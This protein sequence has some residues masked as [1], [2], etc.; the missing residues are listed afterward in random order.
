MGIIKSGRVVIVLAGRYAGRKA[1][2]VSASESGAFGCAV[3][4]GVNRYP[5]K[6]VKAMGKAK[7]EKRTKIKPFVKKINFSHLM[8]TRHMV[9][10]DLK[11]V[12][13]ENPL[14]SENRVEARKAVKKVF[15][16][17]YRNPATASSGKSS[18]KKQ[19]GAQ[20]LFTKLRF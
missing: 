9:D 13:G 5:R 8:P 19:L 17:K 2:V 3:V 14:E 15:E 10:F 18:D 4:A 7:F 6:V 16:D 1:V 11:K 12:I 20:Y